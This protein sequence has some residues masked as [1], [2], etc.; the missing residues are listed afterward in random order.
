MTLQIALLALCAT[1]MLVFLFSGYK[2]PAALFILNLLKKHQVI[3]PFILGYVFMCG[4]S[5]NLGFSMLI[6]LDFFFLLEFYDHLKSTLF[7]LPLLVMT[8]APLTI[9]PPFIIYLSR[10][11]LGGLSWPSS[12]LDELDELDEFKLKEKKVF[13][14]SSKAL[15]IFIFIVPIGCFVSGLASPN[16]GLLRSVFNDHYAVDRDNNEIIRIIHKG[17]LIIKDGQ[18]QFVSFD[19]KIFLVFKN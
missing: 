18:I 19:K 2:H 3:Y 11:I 12:K 4:L 14:P 8:V 1:T 13:M 9:L 7:A 17:T 10:K 5:Y 15:F 16:L 6:G